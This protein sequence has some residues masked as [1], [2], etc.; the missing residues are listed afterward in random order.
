MVEVTFTPVAEDYV[1]MQ[2]AVFARAIRSR[3]FLGRLAGLLAFALMAGI[4]VLIVLDGDVTMESVEAIGSGIAIGFAFLAII[5]GG[6]WLLIPRRARRLFEQQRSL[7]H[8][9]H[10]TLKSDGFRL[11]SVRADSFFPW[12]ELPGWQVSRNILLIF[13][14]DMMAYYIPRRA[15]SDT[16]VSEAVAILTAAGVPRR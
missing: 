3:R 5:V 1:A 10:V 4:A 14:N 15:I 16:Q 9:Q 7:H 11:A 12:N 6:T 8:E 2:R 13:S